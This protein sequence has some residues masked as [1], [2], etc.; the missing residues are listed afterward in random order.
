MDDM[1]AD[2]KSSRLGKGFDKILVPGE[3]EYLEEQRRLK[4]GI[5]LDDEI[6]QSATVITD[7]HQD[8]IIQHRFR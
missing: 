7:I 1:V 3:P 4:T 2:I 8:Q 5:P 6:W